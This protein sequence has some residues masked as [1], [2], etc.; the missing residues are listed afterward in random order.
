M[1]LFIIAAQG[2]KGTATDKLRLVL[3]YLLTAEAVPSEDDFRP[4]EAALRAF[5]NLRYT[6]VLQVL[7][8]PSWR[9]T[10]CFRHQRRCPARTTSVLSRPPCM[11]LIDV[12]CSVLL[13][14]Q[15]C[16]GLKTYR[17]HHVGNEASNGPQKVELAVASAGV[18]EHIPA[19]VSSRSRI[20]QLCTSTAVWGRCSRSLQ[21]HTLCRANE[22]QQ[23]PSVECRC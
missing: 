9:L 20:L 23:R 5:F 15:S 6:L 11:R 18:C 10:Q 14:P 16:P 17:V 7:R 22:P 21:V 2:D 12:H 3:V 8:F 1:L 13:Y 19:E 4:V